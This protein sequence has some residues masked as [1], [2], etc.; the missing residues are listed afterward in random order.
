MSTHN[1]DTDSASATTRSR[2]RGRLPLAEDEVVTVANSTHVVSNR[3]IYVVF[4]KTVTIG[5]EER[6]F[7]D[8]ASKSHIRLMLDCKCDAMK[9]AMAEAYKI[10]N[11]EDIARQG[12]EG[13]ST[14]LQLTIRNLEDA[15]AEAGGEA[16]GVRCCFPTE[17]YSS[18]VGRELGEE[19]SK[20]TEVDEKFAKLMVD[21]D[22]C[23]D[24][25]LDKASIS[26]TLWKELQQA[27]AEYE[28]LLQELD[29]VRGEI[30]RLKDE[31]PTEIST[32][33]V[34]SLT[35]QISG[36]KMQLENALADVSRL[37]VS[38]MSRKRSS[39]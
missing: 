2:T 23:M 21:H 22:K 3:D 15:F 37:H 28:T 19:R 20:H 27:R 12:K 24:L 11:P 16:N 26:S 9:D 14:G 32:A 34:R 7:P 1:N 4:P 6:P 10:H 35:H 8:E 38:P 39:K 25:Q 17:R 13:S 30:C 36:L 31:E 33:Q 18:R 29:D 5:R